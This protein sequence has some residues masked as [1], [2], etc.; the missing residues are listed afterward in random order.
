[1]KPNH[2]MKIADR[3][4]NRSITENKNTST[5]SSSSTSSSQSYMNANL[6]GES[7]TDDIQSKTCAINDSQILLISKFRVS[8]AADAEVDVLDD[9]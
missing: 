7:N 9:G 4:R 6:S 2:D 5:F 1:M 8:K 3:K